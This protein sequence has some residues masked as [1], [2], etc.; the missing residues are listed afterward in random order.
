MLL[1]E[2]RHGARTA[3][4]GSLVTLPEQDRTL[5]DQA[6]IAEGHDIVRRCLRRNEPGPYQIQ[7]AINAVHADAPTADATDWSQIVTLYDQ[8]YALA[9]SPVVALNRA[10]A[11]AETVGPEV[12]LLEVETLDLDGY[13][14]FHVTRAEMLVRL[15]RTDKA[16]VAF[17]RA[18]A[19]AQNSAERD[20]IARRIAALDVS[21]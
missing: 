3:P 14:L 19:L 17:D 5:W 21:P 12:A 1:T 20:H 13:H 10:V 18:L 9:P 2:S 4:D 11:L 16:R 6:L 7:A 15:D 8:L